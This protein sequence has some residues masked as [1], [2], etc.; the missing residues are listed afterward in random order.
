M[1]MADR[2][3]TFVLLTLAICCPF[4]AEAQTKAPPERPARKA[5][6]SCQ[7]EYNSSRDFRIV[8]DSRGW[9]EHAI[10]SAK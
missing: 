1:R 5:A 6:Q 3:R 2:L 8:L 10:R 4:V 9:M 7:M